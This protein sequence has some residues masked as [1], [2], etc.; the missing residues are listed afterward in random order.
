MAVATPAWGQFTE[1]NGRSRITAV[2]GLALRTAHRSLRA[3][4]DG[5]APAG[6]RRIERSIRSGMDDRL[7][8]AAFDGCPIPSVGRMDAGTVRGRS[9]R[10]VEK[11]TA[12]RRAA[13]AAGRDSS[14]GRGADAGQNRRINRN[15][16]ACAQRRI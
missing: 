14:S 13:L 9:G 3:I 2:V 5:L 11:A 12:F 15:R 16:I 1:T 8:V 6:A 4:D 10:A 7:G